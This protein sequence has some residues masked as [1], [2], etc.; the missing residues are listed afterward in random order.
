M[1]LVWPEHVP[2]DGV[3]QEVLICVVSQRPLDLRSL[4]EGPR[5]ERENESRGGPADG[6]GTALFWSVA[7]VE[8]RLEAGPVEGGAP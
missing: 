7:R 8:F 3:G 2:R 4:L 5:V 1:R 6:L